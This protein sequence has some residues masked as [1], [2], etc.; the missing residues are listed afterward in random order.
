M[1]TE[2]CLA[3]L[4]DMLRTVVLVAGPLLVASLIAG[5]VVGVAQTATQVNEPSISYLAKAIAVAFVLLAMGAALA[6]YATTYARASF[7]AVARVVHP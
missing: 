5:L 4:A 2:A 3:L 6:G 7:Q 1:S